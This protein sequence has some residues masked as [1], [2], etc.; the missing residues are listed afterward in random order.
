MAPAKTDP[1]AALRASILRSWIALERFETKTLDPPDRPGRR[2]RN[3]RKFA[4]DIG[5]REPLPWEHGHPACG[6]PLS[7]DNV[8]WR[9]TLHIGQF[10]IGDGY[11]RVE[12]QFPPDTSGRERRPPTRAPA[13]LLAMTVTTDG[14]PVMDSL[15]VSSAAWS[16]AQTLR[17]GIDDP[18]WLHGFDDALSELRGAFEKIVIDSAEPPKPIEPLSVVAAAAAATQQAPVRALS[19]L[20][21]G[22]PDDHGAVS[23]A[24]AADAALDGDDASAANA[25]GVDPDSDTE[26]DVKEPGADSDFDDPRYIDA[27]DDDGIALA[28]ITW[29]HLLRLFGAAKAIL[30][31]DEQL[32]IR[33][34]VRSTTWPESKRVP[35]GTGDT[36][37]NSFAVEDLERIEW[38]LQDGEPG[39]A[40]KRYLG[41]TSIA[42]QEGGD[43]IDV[44]ERLDLVREQ[45]DPSKLPSGRWPADPS[46]DL[47]L[48]QQLAVNLAMQT[49]STA[50]PSLLGTAKF[51]PE[52]SILA[53]NGPPGTGKTTMLRDLIAALVTE[54]ADVIAGFSSADELF[55]GE[56]LSVQGDRVVRVS[57][58]SPKLT[59][60]EILLACATNAAA[61]NVSL[62]L[63]DIGA[64]HAEWRGLG[65]DAGAGAGGVRAGAGRGGGAGSIAAG[66]PASA[67]E[68]AS[69]RGATPAV[70]SIAFPGSTGPDK[71]PAPNFLA[72][73]ATAALRTGAVADARFV[74][75]GPD[76]RPAP[77][78]FGGDADAPT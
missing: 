9:H 40:L 72:D 17:L 57:K 31:L 24:T 76:A 77:Q 58:V 21:D 29:D 41:A 43:R 11:E 12:A 10:D 54:R 8:E 78:L 39:A 33:P 63:P 51:A 25:G 6:A 49:T 23:A 75:T 3:A 37:L 26:A 59:G 53:V 27:I 46:H 2:P 15:Q 60:R 38:R 1:S 62:E 55:K 74:Q 66:A 73:F 45:L 22:P 65:F 56:A 44:D 4:V 28:P 18:K 5:P 69:G 34:V 14:R 52:Q 35:L 7:N 67:R 61:Q 70:G 16:I 36:L 30:E 71:P 68:S 47:A 13:P 48:G 50:A 32:V 64:V 42:E 20:D 19:L